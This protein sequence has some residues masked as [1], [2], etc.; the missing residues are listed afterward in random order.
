M[1]EKQI[2]SDEPWSAPTTAERRVIDRYLT[3]MHRTRTAIFERPRWEE[4]HLPLMYLLAILAGCALSFV[5]PG[6]LGVLAQIMIGGVA[7]L[8]VYSIRLFV[9][10]HRRDLEGRASTGH[11]GG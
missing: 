10:Y 5:L 9:V 3:A 7:G 2:V 6:R 11:G 8:C 1:S 4:R